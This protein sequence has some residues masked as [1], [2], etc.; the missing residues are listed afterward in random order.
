[1]EPWHWVGQ[2]RTYIISLLRETMLPGLCGPG[3][4]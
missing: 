3:K 2:T 1:M 4:G